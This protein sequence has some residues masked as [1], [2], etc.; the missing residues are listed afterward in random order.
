MLTRA[1]TLDE[2]IQI[3]DNCIYDENL[4][5]HGLCTYIS[6]FIGASVITRAFYGS[7]LDLINFDLEV[8]FPEFAEFRPRNNKKIRDEYFDGRPERFW[9]TPDE[10]ILFVLCLREYLLTIK[11]EQNEN[12]VD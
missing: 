8:S 4:L 12:K 11:E 10:R 5:R 3:L 2:K 7:V 9:F 1:L 6:L